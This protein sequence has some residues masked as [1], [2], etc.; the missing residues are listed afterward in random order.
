MKGIGLLAAAV[1][2]AIGIGIGALA[3]SSSSTSGDPGSSSAALR[4][5]CASAYGTNLALVGIPFGNAVRART[6]LPGHPSLVVEA[7][8]RNGGAG[9]RSI[10][11]VLRRSRP[12]TYRSAVLPYGDPI[13]ILGVPS[14]SGQE[15]PAVLAQVGLGMT[16]QPYELFTISARRVVPVKVTFPI[17]RLAASL[18]E[19]R[20]SMARALT[21]QV[22]RADCW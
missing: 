6:S 2:S 13:A 19:V 20:R 7:T 14:Y 5:R 9:G 1:L 3:L 12:I 4:G 10:T 8:C 15:L 11:A 21:V 22:A 17:D 18:A 16:G